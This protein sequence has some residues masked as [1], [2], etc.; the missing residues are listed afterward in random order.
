MYEHPDV[1]G[2][3]IIASRRRM[4]FGIWK[5]PVGQD[6]AQNVRNGIRITQQSGGVYTPTL[7]P[8]DQEVAFLSDSGGHGNIWVKNMQNGDLRQITYEQ[9][10]RNAVGTPVWAPHGRQIAFA[11]THKVANW[12]GVGYSVVDADGSNLHAI[13]QT[14]AWAAWSGDGHW[15]YYT[16]SVPPKASVCRAL[17]ES[18]TRRRQSNGSA[19]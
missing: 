2:T 5:Y 1:A 19:E 11:T 12:A 13:I 6:P 15:I 8:D 10:P 16:E 9:D 14:G 3:K 18:A 17:A 7:S 4:Q